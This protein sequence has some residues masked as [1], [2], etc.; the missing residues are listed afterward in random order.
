MMI[1]SKTLHI[2]LVTHRTITKSFIYIRPWL[3]RLWGFEPQFSKWR[4]SIW[5]AQE[6]KMIV[7]ILSDLL[8]PHRATESI[9]NSGVFL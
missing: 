8:S 9:D 4:L 1:I 7:V 2:Y 6:L 3:H 5:N